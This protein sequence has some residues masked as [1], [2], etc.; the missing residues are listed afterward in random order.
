[1]D[2]RKIPLYIYEGTTARFERVNKRLII[3]LIITI[4]FLFV[5]NIAW[6]WYINQYD[7]I[8]EEITYSQDGQGFNN[9]NTGLQGG[10]RY[11][12]TDAD[13]PTSSSSQN[14]KN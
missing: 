7:F 9:I 10:V 4:V 12:P 11:E 6:L 13:E 14:D 1:M 8:S 5:S 3:A 2:D